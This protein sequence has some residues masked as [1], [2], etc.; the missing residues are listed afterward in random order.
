MADTS[1]REYFDVLASGWTSRYRQ[2]K[3]YLARLRVFRAAIERHMGDG[4]IS[5]VLEVGCGAQ[6]M[7]DADAYPGVEL[8]ATDLSME[9][10]K[11]N[12]AKAR[13]FQ[14]DFLRMPVAGPFDM[15]ILSSVVEWLESPLVAPAVTAQLLAPG[16]VALVSYPNSR[17]MLRLL[18]RTVVTGVKRMFRSRHYTELQ[19]D[20]D[21]SDVDTTFANAG[22]ALH[23]SVFF[24]KTVL[25]D[26]AYTSSMR[27]DTYVKKG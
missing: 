24:G 23:H 18:E 13:F 14:A 9:M 15:V 6:C 21:Y 2:R 22:F 8:F 5:R 19:R 20:V 11:R 25:L 16:G 17:S 1:V 12:P 4:R 10:L 7:F 26:G 3:D 27:L